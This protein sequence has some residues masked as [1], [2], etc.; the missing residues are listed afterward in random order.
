MSIEPQASGAALDPDLRGIIGRPVTDFL[1]VF[2]RFHPEVAAL[3]F[4]AYT[5]EPKLSERLQNMLTQQEQEIRDL[6]VT[7]CRGNG[8]P[9]YDALLGICM[10]RDTV[11]ERF[12]ESAAV[13]SSNAPALTF[14]LTPREVTSTR[15]AEMIAQLPTG[16]GLVV[17]SKLRLNSEAVRQIPMLDFRCPCSSGNAHAISKILLLLGEKQGVLVESGRSYHYYG[18]RLLA[19]SEWIEFMARALLFAPIV[20]PRFVAHRIADG[21]CRLKIVASKEGEIPKIV[22]GYPDDN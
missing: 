16:H 8:I 14:D 12:L 9:F 21:E 18:T 10:R 2:C 7:I 15:I 5:P 11:P 4:A 1:E 6:A 22:D 17:S 3:H 13:H 19:M 20:D